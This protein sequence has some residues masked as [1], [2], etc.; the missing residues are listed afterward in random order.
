LLI[1]GALSGWR[2]VE[3][4]A[5]VTAVNLI[6]SLRVLAAHRYRGTG[7]PMS[8][9]QQVM[10]SNDFPTSLLAEVW[11]PV[12]SRYHAVHHLVPNL[13]YHSLPEAHRRLMGYI[14]QESQF[15]R[16]SRRSFVSALYD[17]L[18]ARPAYGGEP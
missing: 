13:P 17:L 3:A 5:V 2:I 6:N 1:T 12:G 8:F 15:R 9:A 4:Y 11:A 18:V 14:P 7:A 16:T 10:D